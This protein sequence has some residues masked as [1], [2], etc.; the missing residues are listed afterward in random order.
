M[1]LKNVQAY[2]IKDVPENFKNEC[3]ELGKEL[4]KV[5]LPL[6]N[7][8]DP[9]ISLGALT[10]M[11]AAMIKHLISDKEDQQIKAVALSADALIRNV[12]FLN[13]L[14]MEL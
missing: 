1:K 4:A 8:Y 9:N 10:F 12:M 5:I 13:N 14:E 3:L 11:H 7:E 6:M 2:D